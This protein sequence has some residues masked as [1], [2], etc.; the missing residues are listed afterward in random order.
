MSTAQTVQSIQSVQAELLDIFGDMHRHDADYKD[1]AVA[2][3]RLA[4]RRAIEQHFERRQ[5]EKQISDCW[6][7]D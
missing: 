6:I 2:Q 1:K 4:A 7:D 3:R 5:L